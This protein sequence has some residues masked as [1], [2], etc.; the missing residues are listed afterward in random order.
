MTDNQQGLSP[1]S[2]QFFEARSIDPQVAIQLG[3]YTD[4]AK[5][6]IVYP[7]FDRLRHPTEPVNHKY[8]GPEKRFWQD[9]EPYKTFYNANV[10]DDPDLHTATADGG[11]VSAVVT[12]GENDTIAVIQSGHEWCV[13]VPDGAPD[14]RTRKPEE[15]AESREE[16]ERR[17]AQ[18]KY[19]FVFNNRERI[20]KVQRWIIAVDNDPAGQLLAADVVSRLNPAK[21]RFVV[22][23]EGCKDMNDVLHKHGARA[24]MQLLEDAKPYPLDGIFELNDYPDLPPNKPCTT[25]WH[26]MDRHMGLFPG[27]LYGITGVP[28]H[29]KTTW[30]TNLMKNMSEAERWRHLIFT[31]EMPIKPYFRDKLRCQVADM[32]L[33]RL[34]SDPQKLREVDAFI[35]EYFK[36][37]DRDR[38]NLEPISVETIIDRAR[39]AVIRFGINNLLVDPFNQIDHQRAH[40]Q[41]G[42]DYIAYCLRSFK[43]LAV[44]QNIAVGI[45]AHPTKGVGDG[46]TIRVPTLYDIDGAAHWYNMLDLGIVVARGEEN[47]LTMVRV[48]KVRYED[49]GERGDVYFKYNRDSRSFEYRDYTPPTDED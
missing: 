18:G 13:S 47:G 25:G 5:K 35:N 14:P 29:G 9:K 15:E 16:A 42:P 20:E 49:T 27:C 44:E 7:F 30:T 43:Q 36:F 39:Q 45:I 40:G 24:V 3:V 19:A 31:P 17:E 4:K 8:R 10:L 33:E 22:Y 21:C 11:F 48:A 32:S 46:G 34:L 38:R 26:T 1:N 37:I 2:A 12:E 41:S 28:S 23:P 6:A